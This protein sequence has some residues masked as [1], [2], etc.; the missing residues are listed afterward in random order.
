VAFAPDGRT[1]AIADVQSGGLNLLDWPTRSGRGGR[2]SWIAHV[3]LL[4]QE[5]TLTALSFSPVGDLLATTGADG[6]VRLWGTNGHFIGGLSNHTKSVTC[7]AFS[8][9]GHTLVSGSLDQTV[10][11]WDMTTRN[12]GA[13]SYGHAGGCLTVRFA[14]DGQSFASAGL[15]GL[16]K[17]WSLRSSNAPTNPVKALPPGVKDA[18]L[19]ANPAL[20]AMKTA[21][22]AWQVWRLPAC[23]EVHHG[24][25]V[26]GP[27]YASLKGVANGQLLE[28][29]GSKIQFRHVADGRIEPFVTADVG[30]GLSLDLSR[31]SR[32]L[33][34]SGKDRIAAW[35]VASRQLIRRWET[36][37]EGLGRHVRVCPNGRAV[38]TLQKFD[39]TVTFLDL[40]GTSPK[41]RRGH[42]L[43]EGVLNF[44][45]DGQ[46]LAT[47][48]LGAA[49]RIYDVARGEQVM[50]LEGG[51]S[52]ASALAFAFD[53]KRLAC[54]SPQGSISIWDL[55]TRREVA[56]LV[57]HQHAIQSLAFLDADTLASVANDEVRLWRAPSLTTIE[58]LRQ[59]ATAQTP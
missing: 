28:A 24:T 9:D 55:E 26:P 41:V 47:A 15:D 20:L 23:D 8:P 17:V 43:G 37:A 33:A 27:D 39:G 16:L 13:A 49:I 56:L 19:F 5:E 45:P 12:E 32:I 50:A 11:W 48:G 44:S 58:R 59:A 36:P 22:S 10:R 4:D 52:H 21:G 40:A 18:I 35:D 30:E 29:V 31:D 53:T 6:T 34:A 25:H 14:P 38:V 2:A 42:M 3:P 1:L 54:G 51:S 57:G 7:A 46:W